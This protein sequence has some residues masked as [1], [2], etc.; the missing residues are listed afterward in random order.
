[1]KLQARWVLIALALALPCATVSAKD[2]VEKI[3][4]ADNKAEFADQAARVRKDMA[5]GGRYEG[6]FKDGNKSGS[7][8]SPTT[9]P[10]VQ[11][12]IR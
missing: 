7:D 5:D 11:A 1:M 2:R 8:S 6:E 3:V 12:G 10:S 4:Y 9:S